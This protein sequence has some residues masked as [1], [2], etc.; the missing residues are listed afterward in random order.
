[1]EPPGR[2]DCPGDR[3][4]EQGAEDR[5]G[6]TRGRVKR[7]KRVSAPGRAAEDDGRGAAVER[8]EADVRQ[9]A[10]AVVVTQET[11]TTDALHPGEVAPQADVEPGRTAPNLVLEPK[12]GLGE[13]IEDEGFEGGGGHDGELQLGGGGPSS[14]PTELGASRRNS[15]VYR[16]GRQSQTDSRFP[17]P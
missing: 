13:L 9:V 3:E 12:A 14:G 2:R 5:L 6:A 16:F 4:G 10:A 7:L 17:I 1:M 15:R 11:P 8:E